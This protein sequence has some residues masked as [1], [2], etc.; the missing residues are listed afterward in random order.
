MTGHTT[1]WFP[2][3]RQEVIDALRTSRITADAAARLGVSKASLVHGCIVLGVRTSDHLDADRDA[4]RPPVAEAVPY[5]P[6]V[7]VPI[8]DPPPLPLIDWTG[9]RSTSTGIER[10]VILGDLHVPYHSL[11]ACAD[12]LALIRLVQPQKII[13]LGD[14]FNM[15]AVSHHPRP[16][17]GRENH[18][19]AV[20]QGRSFL[21]ALRRAAPGA[22]IHIVMGNHD[23]WADE[24]ED[25]NPQFA[26]MFAAAHV[27]D[28]DRLEVKV[29]ARDRNPLVLGPVGYHHGY[30]GGEHYAKRY[31][32]DDAP[33][34][35]V[36]YYKVGH[37]HSVQRFHARNGVECWG[38]GWLGR[39]EPEAFRYA[40]NNGGWE[41]A[42]CVE[43]VCGDVVTTTPV[44]LGTG[45]IVFGGRVIAPN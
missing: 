7:S 21:E 27:L 3:R 10:R 31:A 32:I 6:P 34:A 18:S 5:V 28:A 1:V 14:Y 4:S 24:Y 44:R 35:G 25:E 13:Q 15:G 33:K 37:H 36:L 9:A 12:A 40:K 43:D 19:Q 2:A 42:L 30:G 16:F 29:H 39:P 22:E 38:V 11:P 23:R 45:R 17:G 20:L 26:G 8:E 41:N